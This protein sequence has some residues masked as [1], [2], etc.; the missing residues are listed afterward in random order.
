MNLKNYESYEVDS[1]KAVKREREGLCVRF[2]REGS[3]RRQSSG[4]KKEREK[5]GWRYEGKSEGSWV[6]KVS[7]MRSLIRMR[8]TVFNIFTKMPLSNNT[9][10]TKNWYG[11]VL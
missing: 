4:R 6:Q 9:G 8:P 10:K 5:G 11:G 7:V 2:L 1:N 3:S